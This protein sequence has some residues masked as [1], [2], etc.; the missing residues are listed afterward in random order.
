MLDTWT[1]TLLQ[2]TICYDIYIYICIC[3]VCIWGPYRP[4]YVPTHG[5]LK[6]PSRAHKSAQYGPSM[7]PHLGPDVGPSEYGPA[8]WPKRG[9]ICV[10]HIPLG[11]SYCRHNYSAATHSSTPAHEEPYGPMSTYNCTRTSLNTMLSLKCNDVP[12]LNNFWADPGC[13]DSRMLS[14]PVPEARG[15]VSTPT[16]FLFNDGSRG[17]LNDDL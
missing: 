4:T 3:G 14:S 5:K 15:G 13:A 1:V 7:A 11:N 6:G 17:R 10:V 8:P 9:P 12:D 2:R 16:S